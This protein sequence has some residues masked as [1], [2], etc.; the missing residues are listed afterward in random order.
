MKK[1][2]ISF[3]VSF[4]LSFVSLVIGASFHGLRMNPANESGYALG[5]AMGVSM[6][7]C[8][9]VFFAIGFILLL[10]YWRKKKKEQGMK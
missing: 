5:V 7:S 10:I 4:A 8:A 2:K 1:L 3:I 9:A 6:A